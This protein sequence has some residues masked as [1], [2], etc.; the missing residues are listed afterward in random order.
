M[1]PAG[2]FTFAAPTSS[3]DRVCHA[4]TVCAPGLYETVPF[5]ASSDRV[6]TAC[7]HGSMATGAACTQ[8]GGA[9]CASCDDGYYLSSGT[10][11]P[12]PYCGAGQKITAYST[13]QAGCISS[14]R[15]KSNQKKP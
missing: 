10:C 13:T 2:Q 6:C 1:C 15:W 7:A 5:G 3:A 9:T 8:H 14:E 12:Q 11:V 4:I